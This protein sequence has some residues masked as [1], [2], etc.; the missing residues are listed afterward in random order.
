MK[1]LSEFSVKF[2]ITILMIVLSIILLGYI[3]FDKLGMDLFPDLNN[4]RIFIEL[5]AG[6]RPPEEME[7]QFVESMEAIAVRQRNVIQVSSV[8][9]VGAAEITVEFNWDADMDEA[10]LDLQKNLGN[11]TQN[12]DLEEITFDQHDPNSAAVMIIGFSHPDITD[13]D[14]LR[15]IAENYLRNELI[16]LDGIAAVE[17]IGG[18]E[19]EIVI[20]TSP[21]KLEAFNI[22][23]SE[24][25][26][27]IL[28]SNRNISG[29]SIEEM[30][31]KYVIKGLG[32]FQSLE[33][34]GHVIVARDQDS[35]APV[36]LH[37]IADI[38][39]KNKDPE[40]IV[41]INGKRCIALAIYKE[42]K[43]NTVKAVDML[44]DDLNDLKKALPGYEFNIIRNQAEFIK[45]AIN[46]VKET[47]LYGILLAVIILFVFLRRIGITAIISISI[48]I[49]I[50][51]TFNLMYFNG[52]SLNIMTLGGLALGAGM[53]VD[54]AIVVMENIYRNL[55]KGVSLKEAA[56][57]GTAEVGGAITASTIT[58]VIVFLPIIYLH[59]E[60]GELFKDQA[61]TVAFSLISSLFVAILVI[62]ML[63]V[64]FLK[65]IS[66]KDADSPIH[67]KWYRNALIKALEY[68]RIILI[69]TVLLITITA[70]LIPIIGSE[71][72][73]KAD[74]NAFQ[75]EVVLDEGS[76]LNHT[77]RVTSQLEEI[78]NRIVG[79][80]VTSV[81]SRVGPAVGELSDQ[82]GS[83]LDDEN[84]AVIQVNL[85]ADKRQTT[86]QIIEKLNVIFKDIPNMKINFNREQSSLQSTIG[87]GEAPVI[88]EI[89]GESFDVI[90][91]LSKNVMEQMATIDDIFNIETSFDEGRPEINIKLDRIRAGIHDIDFASV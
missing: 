57:N 12:S 62:P 66:A 7:K 80:D 2:P 19:K 36:Y 51:A 70:F 54:N 90:Q 85:K 5:K 24:V 68:R 46:E 33:D 21:Y 31:L 58:T 3:S 67:F 50:I 84:R 6:E 77:D 79:D 15:K 74:S 61:W 38:Y 17:I 16:R 55:E 30:G 26:N 11:F 45:T 89:K 37:N 56:I 71:F 43:F 9:R 86:E 91:S 76:A 40:N 34:I 78:V 4:P 1:S 87:G 69:A 22:E 73:P 47:A 75:V 35:G 44:I 20:Q 10:L 18:E 28:S 63:S 49:S 52:L 64:R 41:R 42:T 82:S 25:A 81:Y 23:V 14:E 13:M 8:C 72:M 27:K 32:E 29:G 83:F 65:P 48:P 53:L 39:Y 59:G 88:V 60:A